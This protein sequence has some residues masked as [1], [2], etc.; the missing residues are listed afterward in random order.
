VSASDNFHVTKQNMFDQNLVIGLVVLAVV[1][2]AVYTY[3]PRFRTM[4][5]GAEGF[6]SKAAN[7]P[8]K[9]IPNVQSGGT[10]G[11][12]KNPTGTAAGVKAMNPHVAPAPAAKATEQFADYASV[13]EELGP[14]PMAGAAKPQGCYPRQ[15]LAAAELLP[16]DGASAWAAANPVGAG[17][18]QG[19]N[20]LS[21]GA[22]IGINTVGQSLRNANRQL[23]AEPPNPQV[24][25]GPWQQSTIEPD[26]QRRPL[27]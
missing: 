10:A 3:A 17:D 11:G 8:K 21:A 27:E 25:V 15:Q 23:R 12:S 20:F 22:L 1:V 26:L 13:G 16:H 9:L 4:F 5:S 7:A 18:L 6:E 14:V 2:L 19:K 24:Q